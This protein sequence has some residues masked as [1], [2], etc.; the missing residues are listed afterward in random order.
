MNCHNNRISFL[1]YII[2]VTL[3]IAVV[4]L[5]IELS[6]STTKIEERDKSSFGSPE[7]RVQLLLVH[8]PYALLITSFAEGNT[9]EF[10]VINDS[11]FGGFLEH[12][13]VD[14]CTKTSKSPFRV[15]GIGCHYSS[16]SLSFWFPCKCNDCIFHFDDFHGYVLLS[17]ME[18]LQICK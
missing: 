17:H 1:V 10:K 6:D 3:V 12:V 8:G 7:N 18:D 13:E 15:D 11:C 4:E 16:K 2:I 14:I 9:D 5:H